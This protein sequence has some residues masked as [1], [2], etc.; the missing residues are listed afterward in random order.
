MGCA[1]V[2]DS[3]AEHTCVHTVPWAAPVLC[4]HGTWE[5]Q[6]EEMRG[7]C[8]VLGTRA[9]GGSRPSYVPKAT[10]LA[11]CAMASRGWGAALCR[12]PGE[13]V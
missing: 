11:G 1:G 9:V 7:E 3:C 2:R 12:A 6:G 5:K 13:R 8:W 4:A 10:F